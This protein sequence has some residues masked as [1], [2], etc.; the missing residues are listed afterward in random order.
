MSTVDSNFLVG[1]VLRGDEVF[2]DKGLVCSGVKQ[3][4]GAIYTIH[5]TVV[6]DSGLLMAIGLG[7]GKAAVGWASGRDV[8]AFVA[9]ETFDAVEFS[10]PCR[11]QAG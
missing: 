5:S 3:N 6:M 11:L 7:R 10:V 2:T 1:E 9:F 8:A 4:V